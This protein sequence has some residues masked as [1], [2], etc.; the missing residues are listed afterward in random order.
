M[1]V[2]RYGYSPRIDFDTIRQR[3]DLFLFFRGLIMVIMSKTLNIKCD[4]SLKSCK[5]KKYTL[6]YKQEKR[7]RGGLN[8]K[9][10]YCR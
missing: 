3:E 2:I 10:H 4:F 7:E 8:A 9:N 1:D 5:K 6:L